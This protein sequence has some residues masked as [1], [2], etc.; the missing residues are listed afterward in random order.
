[1]IKQIQR[2]KEDLLWPL[3]LHGQQRL[4]P[5]PQQTLL[6]PIKVLRW[7]GKSWVNPEAS[8]GLSSPR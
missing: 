8:N 6:L 4:Q 5:S 2:G 1:M 3:G 7:E